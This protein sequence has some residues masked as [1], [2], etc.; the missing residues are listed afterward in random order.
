MKYTN[1]KECSKYVDIDCE[2][3]M[4]KDEA[5]SK[6][7]DRIVG[8]SGTTLITDYGRVFTVSG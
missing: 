2:Y 6:Y 1:M 4:E 3:E 5:M 7:L 8:F